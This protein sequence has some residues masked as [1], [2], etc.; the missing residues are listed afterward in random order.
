MYVCECRTIVA[1]SNVEDYNLYVYIS[2]GR[3]EE[4]SINQKLDICWLKGYKNGN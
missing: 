1:M 3:Y 4:L 2:T